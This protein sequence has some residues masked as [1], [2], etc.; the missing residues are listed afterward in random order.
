[1]P[2]KPSPCGTKA[3]YE[4]HL[5]SGEEPCEACTRANTVAQRKKRDAARKPSE[6]LKGVAAPEAD[7]RLED[8]W[9]QR[10]VLW[11]AIQWA[12][13]D[14]PSRVAA[15][16]KELR[17]IRREIDELTEDSE[18]VNDEFAEFFATGGVTPISA[19]RKRA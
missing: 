17:E 14:D 8:L 12:I 1:M 19:A 2:R 6:P 7:S 5:R 11:Q 16:S 10:E 4:R 13:Q 9:R 3:A 18:V 15:L